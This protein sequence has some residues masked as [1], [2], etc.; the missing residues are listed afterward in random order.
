MTLTVCLCACYCRHR[1]LYPSLWDAL[2]TLLIV[3]AYR[4][5]TLPRK[6]ATALQTLG[7]HS[8]NI[9]LFHTFIYLYYFHD[10]IYWSSNPALVYLTLLAICLPLS[11]AIERLKCL[12]RIDRLTAWAAG[13]RRR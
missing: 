1:V 11:M 12:V 2:T 9:F 13:E 5:V 10:L 3:A 6:V 7:R 8:A 4:L